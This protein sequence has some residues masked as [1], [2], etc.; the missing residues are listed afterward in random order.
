MRLQRAAL[1]GLKRGGI[2]LAL[3]GLALVV[4]TWPVWLSPSSRVVGAD[5]SGVW[6][7]MWANDW[8]ASRLLSDGAWPL[9]STEFAFPRQGPFSS[10][11][12]VNDLLSLLPQLLFE[13]PTTHN[14]LALF[15]VLLACT[16]GY[17]LARRL[18]ATRD[19]SL[20]GGGVFG[21]NAFLLSYGLASGVVETWSAGWIAWHVVALLTLIERPRVSTAIAAGLTFTALGASSLYWALLTSLLLPLI[22]LPM[23][24]PALRDPARR[25]GFLLHAG[26]AVGVAALTL[27]P[28]VAMLLGTYTADEAVLLNYADR[29]QQLLPAGVMAGM[30]HDFATVSGYFVPG[31]TALAVH[32][33]MDR[34]VQ[35]TYA[36]WL[37]LGLA[38]AGLERGRWR[39]LALVG[40]AGLFSLGPYLPLSPQHYS[41]QPVWFWSVLGGLLPPVRMITSYVRFS[42]F[43]FLGLGVLSA[44]GTDRLLARLRGGGRSLRLAGAAVLALVVAET[45]LFSPVPFPLPWANASVPEVSQLLVELPA[46]GAVLDW[47]QRYPGRTTEISRY[48]YYQSVH[49][50][51]V[52]YD[53]A[54]TNY[55]PGPVEGNAFIARMERTTYGETY[56]S[57]A[58]TPESM[59]SPLVGAAQLADMGYAYLVVHL[60]HVPADR[61]PLLLG[62]LDATLE[63]EAET[64]DGLVY[65]LDSPSI[66]RAVGP[67]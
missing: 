27:G 1:D 25:R 21:L 60:E 18:G 37:A 38:A 3:Y 42:V 26:L 44:F 47:P 6:R 13:L 64:A 40:V 14:L 52:A 19:G 41:G 62:F 50:R 46:A 30:A 20:V 45:A 9:T 35:T 33:N 10:I 65:R 8:T 55:M 4:L 66:R 53:F 32:D 2:P 57:G 54:P 5:D 49:G 48:F 23:A 58:W 56:Q 22:A 36:G 39:W 34:L 31:E 67:R 59:G 11:A 16:G 24:W 7:A 17:A 12:P 28:I 63:L 15:H 51:P 43:V 29:K 61:A